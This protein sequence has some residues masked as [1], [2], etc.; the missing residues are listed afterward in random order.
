MAR[1]GMRRTDPT[2]RGTPATVRPKLTRR[3][4]CGAA[5]GEWCYRDSANG[6]PVRLKQLHPDR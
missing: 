2:V 6:Y 3:C 5:P 1:I 4:R